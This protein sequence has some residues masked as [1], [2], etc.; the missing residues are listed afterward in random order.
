M[1]SRLNQLTNQ[2]ASGDGDDDDVGKRDTI[3]WDGW[4]YDDTFFHIIPNTDLIRVSGHRY[5]VSGLTMPNLLPFM[6]SR[7]VSQTAT[8]NDVVDINQV[9]IPFSVSNDDFVASL[10]ASIIVDLSPACRIRHSHGHSL[11]EIY[12][13]RKGLVERVPDSVAYVNSESDVK[14][15][16][17]RATQ[18]SVVLI[19]FG[20]G[21][22]VSQALKCNPNESRHICSVDL[23]QM[24]SV[25]WVDKENLTAEVQCGAIGPEIE[26]VLSQNGLCLGHEP[27]SHEFS[28]LGGW[29]ATRAS[30][31]KKNAYGNIEDIVLRITCITPSGV[32]EEFGR[33]PRQSTGPD[34]KQ[35]VLGSEGIL[36]IITSAVL[37][38]RPLPVSTEYAS[39]I[40]P[41]FASGVAFMRQVS[42]QRVAPASIRLV[43]NEQFQFGN[44][45]KPEEK[46]SWVNAR[47]QDSFRKWI[48]TKLGYDLKQ[49]VAC[50][51]LFEGNSSEIRRQKWRILSIGW[52]FGGRSAGSDAGRRGYRL[53]FL[54]AYIRDFTLSLGLLAES[55]ETS[56]EWDRVVSL[57]DNVK[58]RIKQ[59]CD[60]AGALIPP[61]IS[62]R[63]T[64]VYDTGAC[65]YFYFG[66]VPDGVDNPVEAFTKI[67]HEARQEVLRSGGSLSH[68]HG[69]GQI[70]KQ[71]M[72]QVTSAASLSLLKAV[73]RQVDPSNVFAVGN[74]VD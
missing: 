62:C 63:V 19:P 33:C 24:N 8:A 48:I 20:G 15:L 36:G 68:H 9:A 37:R 55:F 53:T 38:V 4:G 61:F 56:V 30:G 51:I 70:R 1:V 46:R 25:L 42:R 27:D 18:H 2:I 23:S 54:I 11:Q 16:I 74:L 14:E 29:I 57:C 64:Q 69:V 32:L 10:P 3:R 35:L 73:K 7:G 45:I 5:D 40:F 43:D 65:I 44:A 71:F 47:F 34:I 39:L 60:D 13:L 41:D 72:G 31:M 49:I 17:S 67:E 12:N 52:E 21:T 66:L 26:R 28:T 22:S 58:K 50:T 6:K 59:S